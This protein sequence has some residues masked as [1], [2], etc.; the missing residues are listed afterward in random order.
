MLLFIPLIFSPLIMNL[1]KIKKNKLSNESIVNYMGGSNY[2]LV[3]LLIY[4]CII[5]YFFNPVNN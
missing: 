1:E 5:A 2:S 3:V 4:L